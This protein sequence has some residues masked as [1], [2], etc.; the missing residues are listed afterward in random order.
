MVLKVFYTNQNPKSF[1]WR[2]C[3]NFWWL[4]Q[5]ELNS[6]LLE[7]EMNNADLPESTDMFLSVLDK[8]APK[9]QKFIL[10]NNAYFI[11]KN[12]K[13]AIM[14]RLKLRN[15]YLRATKNKAKKSIY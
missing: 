6:W 12:L 1:Q 4:F 7:I 8:H 13:K 9:K 2:S 3:K 11:T 14:K 15:K 5:K 10:Q